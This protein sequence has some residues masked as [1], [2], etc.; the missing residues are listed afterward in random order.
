MHTLKPKYKTAFALSI[1]HSEVSG[2][3]PQGS[4]YPV[5]SLAVGEAFPLINSSLLSSFWSEIKDLAFYGRE[6]TPEGKR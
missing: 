1:F 4:S 6:E 3:L 5:N 2:T